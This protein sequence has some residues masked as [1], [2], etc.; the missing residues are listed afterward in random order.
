VRGA[1]FS[2]LAAR[3]GE[4]TFSGPADFRHATFSDLPVFFGGVTF[5]S[6]ANFD[7]ATFFTWAYFRGATFKQAATFINAKMENK[8]SFEAAIFSTQPPSFF[9]AKLHEG[10]EWG[11]VIWPDAPRDPHAARE[12]VSAYERLKLEMDRLKKH[13]DELDFFAREQQCRRVVLGRWA[14]LP[15]ATYGFLSDYG[16][17]YLRPLLLLVATVFLGTFSFAAHLVGYWTPALSDMGHTRQA[18]GLSFANT[19]GV[20]NIRKDFIDPGM[21][22]HLPDWLKVVSTIQTIIGLVLLFLF[23]LGIRNRFR[24]K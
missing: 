17:S 5:S 23:G 15:I 20:L 7:D 14:G 21:L 9:G 12:F 3:F 19:F 22:L 8:T 6:V 1:A 2:A 16:R 24:M 13:G 4:V 11:D 10:T 18:I